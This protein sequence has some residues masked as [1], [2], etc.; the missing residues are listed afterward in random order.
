MSEVYNFLPNV[1]LDGPKKAEGLIAKELLLIPFHERNAIDEEVHGVHNISPNETPELLQL[2]MYLLSIELSKIPDK[3][4]FDKS[5]RL[6]PNDTYVNTV[7]F[8]LRFLRCEIFDAK[9]AAIRMVTFLDFLDDLFDGNYVLRRPIEITD[10]SKVEMK[11]LRTGICQLLPYRDRS[12]R[13]VYIEA[14][15]MGFQI[16]LKL[17]MRIRSYLFFV[18]SNDTESQK[19]GMVHVTWPE[20]DFSNTPMP[21]HNES[22]G[23]IKRAMAGMPIRIA[24]IHFCMPDTLYFWLLRSFVTTSMYFSQRSRIR[25]HVAEGVERRYRLQGYGIPVEMIPITDSG[26]VKRAYLYQ[27]IKVRKII[28]SKENVE[29]REYG[30]IILLPGSNDVLIRTGTTTLSHPGNAFF[31]SL[32]EM[33]H[34]EFR[35]GSEFTQA[36]LA[37]HVVKEIERLNGRFLTWDSRG[38]WTELRDRRQVKFKV[39]ISIRDFKVKIKARKN[40]QSAHSSTHSF[41]HQDG[42][43]GKRKKL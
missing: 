4:A 22:R 20:G 38:Y 14:G 10:L 7:D 15:D 25:F 42:N 40:E 28:E 6:F 37:E 2:S 5:Q 33:K 34:I 17:R 16:D 9:K 31:R 13:P 8:R 11:I 35:S 3:P 30:S 29:N 32:I 19:K 23:L 36:F 1:P 26:N 18:A 21:L 41:E 24:V 12:G 39:E 43:R 27:W